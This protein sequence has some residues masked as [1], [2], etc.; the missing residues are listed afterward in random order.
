MSV[1]EGHVGAGVV[2]AA[3]PSPCDRS[4]KHNDLEEMMERRRQIACAALALVALSGLAGALAGCAS[5]SSSDSSGGGSS[6]AASTAAASLAAAPAAGEKLSG[7]GSSHGASGQNVS[8][9]GVQ[10]ARLPSDIIRTAEVGLQ[11]AHGRVARDLLHITAIAGQMGGYVAQ[12]TLGSD[13]QRSGV[14]VVRVPV[15]RFGATLDAISGLGRVQSESV[16]GQDVS[17]EFVDLGAR[18]QNLQAQ[19]G[20]LRGLMARATTISDSIDIENHLT[21][22]ELSIERITG[23]LRYLRNRTSFSTITA[24]LS[25]AGAAPPVHHHASSLW[26]AAARSLHGAQSVVEAVIVGAGYVV[27]LTV[28][29]LLALVIGRMLWPRVRP[30]PAPES[31]PADT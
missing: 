7:S 1:D 3:E 18:L 11:V 31:G 13:G 16:N 23:Q 5:S 27:P 14:I 24:E 6:T 20:F 10:P 15:R 9:I 4:H 28:L 22:V 17:Q 25:E 29:A 12:D 21:D 8:D 19:Q 26:K 2:Q 30:L